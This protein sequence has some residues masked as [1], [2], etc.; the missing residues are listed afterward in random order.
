MTTDHRISNVVECGF[1]DRQA[2]FLVTV[3][4]HAGVCLGR[5]Y[6]V[7]GGIV[8][9]QRTHDFFSLLTSRR[10]ATRYPSAHGHAHIYHVHGKRL[11][12]AI[13]EPDNRHRKPVT[14][15]R[16][17]ERL[18]VLDVVLA[19]P[20]I[21]WLGTERE[22]RAYFESATTLRTDELPHIAFGG[23]AGRT[24]RYFP[25]KL[26][27]GI[28]ADGRTH[29]FLYGVTAESTRDFRPFLH[30]HAEL[31]R[32]LSTWELRLLVPR[33]L[34]E[35][36]PR[37][38]ATAREELARPLGLDRVTEMQRYFRQRQQVDAGGPDDG[39]EYERLRKMFSAPR[40]WALYRTWQRDG[41]AV[42]HGTASPTL[43]DALTRQSGQ[44][45]THVLTHRYQHLTSLVG[46]A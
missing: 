3:M 7:H 46:T 34:A 18:M 31:W 32:A 6:C 26:P 38:A 42:L 25:D 36:A 14:L 39:V 16:A 9:G 20:E 24:V 43:S 15:A 19:S 12:R 5:Q 21:Q 30:R 40:Y 10:L 44:V 11:Y 8:R 17:I 45:T 23:T 33:H 35:A 13:G 41:E 22:K 29:V 1:T 4:V 37:F 27:I 2:R 28:S